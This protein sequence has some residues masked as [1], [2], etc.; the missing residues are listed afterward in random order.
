[1]K[2]TCKPSEP[3]TIEKIIHDSEDGG[4]GIITQNRSRTP[5]S[6]IENIWGR[7]RSVLVSALSDV[8]YKLQNQQ[9][10][11]WSWDEECGTKRSNIYKSCGSILKESKLANISDSKQES[12]IDHYVSVF[13]KESEFKRYQFYEGKSKLWCRG[14]YMTGPKPQAILMTLCLINLPMIIYYGFVLPKINSTFSLFWIV[15]LSTVVHLMSMYCM[16]K[17][18]TSNPGIIPKMEQDPSLL[19][20]I[21][22]ARPTKYSFRMNYMGTLVKHVH[23]NNCVVVGPPRTRHCYFCGNC[24]ELFDHH[25]PWLSCCVGKRNYTY[26]LVFI[27]TLSALFILSM[28]VSAFVLLSS[29]DFVP[30]IPCIFVIVYNIL[31]GAFPV[32]LTIYHYFLVISGETTYENLKRLYKREKNPFKKSL[33]HNLRTRLCNTMGTNKMRQKCNMFDHK[34]VSPTPDMQTLDNMRNTGKLAQDIEGK[35]DRRH[36]NSDTLNMASKES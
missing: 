22:Q 21:T 33:I 26:F 2:I 7:N 14:V 11:N 29:D 23:C 13:P 9:R 16:F 10:S 27:S 18:C 34:T 35:R 17:T 24:V 12:N 1:M 4:I 6:K 20:K 19:Y 25:C 8:D 32:G 28:I 31:V 3:D 15:I 5:S 36:S 30:N